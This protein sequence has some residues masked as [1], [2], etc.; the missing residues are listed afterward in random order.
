MPLQAKLVREPR[1]HSAPQR[2]GH[3]AVR[4]RRCGDPQLLLSEMPAPTLHVSSG[5]LPGQISPGCPEE[6]KASIH[7][8]THTHAHTH[9]TITRLAVGLGADVG[10]SLS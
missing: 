10:S 6:A 4:D 3:V 5:L 1:K 9:Y 7:T 8:N 2:R